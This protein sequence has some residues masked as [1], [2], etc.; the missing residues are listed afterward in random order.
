MNCGTTP[1]RQGRVRWGI[2]WVDHGWKLGEHGEWA[3]Y[4]NFENDTNAPLLLS[5]HAMKNAGW[6]SRAQAEFVD[7]YPT[8]GELAGLPSSGHL[9]VVRAKPLLE[10]PKRTWKTAAFSQYPQGAKVI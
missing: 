6:H 8:L 3:K 4:I 2:V 7:V 5:V 1:A 10:N 9:G